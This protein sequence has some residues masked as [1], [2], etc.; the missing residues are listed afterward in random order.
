MSKGFG[1]CGWEF[2]EVVWLRVGLGIVLGV[3]F[4]DR[5]FGQGL[6]ARDMV[7]GRVYGYGLRSGFR[8]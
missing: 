6:W 5:G 1:D 2:R 3:G 7:R 8:A 4:M